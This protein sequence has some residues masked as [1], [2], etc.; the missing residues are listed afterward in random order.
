M[1]ILVTGG[2]GYIGSH[3]VKLLLARGHD[4]WVYDNLVAGPPRRRARRAARSSA[5]CA[6]IDRLDHVLVDNRIEAVVHFAAFAT[7]ASRSRDPAKYYTNNLVNTLNLIDRCRRNGIQ[8]FVFSSTCATYG[9]PDA[10]PITEDE[11]QQPI[12]PY[13]NTQAGRRA[14]PGRLRRRLRLGLRRPALLQRRRRQPRTA[15]IGEDHDPETHLIPLVLQAA[16]GQ[17]PHIEIFGTDYPTPDGTCVRDYIHVDDLAEAHLLALEKLRAGQGAALQPRHRPR[18]Q[19][20]RGD[21]AR[22]RR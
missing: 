21:R 2:A 3:A 20:P 8:R 7:S 4:V 10:V 16:L 15:R 5:I 14:G 13:G 6:T 19:R 17:R 11:P 1:R 9:M 18:L 12:N 22:S